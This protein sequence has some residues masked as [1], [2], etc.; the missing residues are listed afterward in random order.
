MK[1]MPDNVYLSIQHD[2]ISNFKK[3]SVGYNASFSKWSTSN[4]D[5][6]DY[7]LGVDDNEMETW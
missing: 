7:A 1:L 2:W 3:N 4:G 5:W 6:I